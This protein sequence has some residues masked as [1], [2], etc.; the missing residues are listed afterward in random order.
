MPWRMHY[1]NFHLA[2][3]KNLVV[4][5]D[6][7]I[8]FWLGCRSVDNSSTCFLAQ[9][10][11]PTDE[12]SVKVRF[13]NVFEFDAVLFEAIEVGFCFP[14]RINYR[15]FAIGNDI[16]CA[17]CQATGIDLFDFHDVIFYH[18]HYGLGHIPFAT[19]R[20]ARDTNVAWLRPFLLQS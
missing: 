1:F 9:V 5:S 13:K 15:S 19:L 3:F 6:D 4:I 18:N 8:E 20:T 17:L 7:G 10:E 16:I 12:V 14:Q 2:Q 11:M